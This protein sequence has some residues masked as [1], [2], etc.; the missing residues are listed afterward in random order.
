MQYVPRPSAFPAFLWNSDSDFRFS[1]L[2]HRF[3]P[4]K[5]TI[6]S[7]GALLDYQTTPKG[8]FFHSREDSN[9]Y[10]PGRNRRPFP[11]GLREHVGLQGR[12]R[13]DDYQLCRLTPLPLGDL[14]KRPTK[15]ARA[16]LRASANWATSCRSRRAGL[17]PA[18]SCVLCNV[19]PASIR[20][21]T[22]DENRTRFF[23]VET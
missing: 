4:T 3:M 16:V 21:R 18:T 2:G 1:H 6:S 20:S 19:L 23:R 11:V 7:V 12:T 5:Y 13:T 10:L 17:E 15:V 22:G 9:P 8:I 14:E